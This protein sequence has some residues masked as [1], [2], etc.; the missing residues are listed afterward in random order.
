[1]IKF[2]SPTSI[3][4]F[5]RDVEAFIRKYVFR[6]PREPQTQ[7]MAAGSAFDAFIKSCLYGRLIGSNAKFELEAIFESQV[8]SHNRDWAWEAGKHIFTEY[9]KAGCVQDLLVEMDGRIG[10]P[11]FEFR[12]EETIEGVPL[13]GL[14]DVYFTSKE[15]S[16]VLYDFK[17]NGYCSPRNTS[18]AKGYVRLRPGQK[19]HKDCHLLMWKGIQIN[20]GMF[21]EQVNA[22]WCDQLSIYSWLMGAEVGSTNVVFGIDQICGP[23]DKMRF[24]SHRLRVTPEYQKNLFALIR[25]IWA[26]ITE[27]HY[28]LDLDPEESRARVKLMAARKGQWYDAPDSY[29][30]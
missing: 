12:I 8:E 17:V 20:A 2:L 16:R 29:F 4:L 23:K 18:P 1:M 5:N 13:L 14:P 19:I 30:G 26:Q 9:E 7:P 10:D 6:E 11:V 3:G 22:S 15:A 27:D 25:Q 21:L 24:A 28:F